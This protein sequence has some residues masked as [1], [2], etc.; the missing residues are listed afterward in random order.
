MLV[1]WNGRRLCVKRF[2]E[3]AI[4]RSTLQWIVQTLAV[5]L[6]VNPVAFA[7][8][9]KVPTASVPE[10]VRALGVGHGASVWLNDGGHKTGKIA[11]IDSTSFTLESGHKHGLETF[12]FADVSKV[13]K[14]GLT[15]GTKV[16][17]GVAVGLGVLGALSVAFR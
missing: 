15:R 9:D 3:I 12:T 13:Q 17:I 6:V 8:S 2:N 10:Q 11:S 7:A 14:S 16:S 4:S 1:T 5:L